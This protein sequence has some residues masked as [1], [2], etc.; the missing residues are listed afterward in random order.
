MRGLRFVL[1]VLALC[2]IPAMAC[3]FEGKVVGVSDGDTIKVLTKN[4]EQ[5]R[6]RLY[7]VDCPESKQAFGTKAKRF[8][9]GAVFGKHVN[10]DVMD[11]DRYGRTVGIVTTENGTV[12][13]REL[14]A[15]GLA[16]VYHAYCHEPFC[17]EWGD[18]EYA[19]RQAGTGLWSEGDRC[20]SVGI[21]EG[22]LPQYQQQR[23]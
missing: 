11:T 16:W 21:Q 13:N 19:A 8:M 5:V 2:L 18:I 6:V 1:L 10:V 14:L 9:S 12:I 4:N 3:A 22:W 7:G 23:C 17:D 15:S 20:A